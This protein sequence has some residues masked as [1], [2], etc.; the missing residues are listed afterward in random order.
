MSV[1]ENCQKIEERILKACQRSGRKREEVVLLAASKTQ[2]VEKILQAYYCGIRYFGENRVQEGIEKIEAL[3]DYK[4]IHW[5]L[6]GGLQTNKVKYAVK[7]FEMIH[8][9]DREELV[10]EIEKRASKMNKIQEGLIEVNFGEES[11]YGVKE[12]NLKKL[13]E[14]ILTKEHIK[15]LGLMAIPPY[16][17]NPEDVRPFFRKLRQLKED[18]E[19]DFNVKLPHLSMGMSHDFEVAIEEGA[20]IVRIGTALFGERI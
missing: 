13:F 18:L 2:P 20:T 15:I 11:K 19:K 10:D 17:E 8:S 14:Y 1:K 3:K 5:H 7:Y 12:E 9:I 16:F 4:D 6:I